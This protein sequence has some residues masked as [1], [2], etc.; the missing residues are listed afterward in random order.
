MLFTQKYA[1]RKLEEIFGNDEA[2]ER[3]KQWILNW[4]RGKR[5]KPIL[6]HGPPGTGKSALAAALRE[7]FDLEL[8]EMSASDLRNRQ[9]VERVMTN[10]L[11]GSS[12]FGR[13]KLIFIDDVDALQKSDSGGSTAISRLLG[14]AAAP[15]MLTA[16]NIWE[17]KLAGIRTSCELLAFKK[18]SKPSIAKILKKITEKEKLEISEDLMLRILEG[19]S[20]DVRSA[21]N[22]LQAHNPGT[23]EREKDIFERV[24][25]VFKSTT[26]Q[27]AKK[28]VEG[29]ADYEILKLWIDEN[30]PYEYETAEDVA[31]AYNS[32][33]R[34]DVFEG[35]IRKSHW[36]Y[37]RYVLDLMTAGV[38][39]SKKTR[40][41][42]FTKYQF[43]KYLRAMAG[44]VE[45]RAMNKLVGRKI[46]ARTHDSWKFS[47]SYLPIL[48]ALAKE[49]K[50]ALMDFYGLDDDEVAFVMNTDS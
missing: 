29:D 42:K 27:D 4:M 1:P 20:G 6:V 45:K 24:L 3:I 30:I 19:A 31:A 2:R 50:T 41:Q 47:L 10:A 14:E 18:I 35:R 13:T 40:Y 28:A 39:L 16:T 8:I 38:A 33:S 43:P 9:H 36:T 17:K 25:K 15:I 5:Q 32:L 22:D 34:A 49:R 21:I 44:T 48:K 7:E 12:L 26:Y 37:L 46:G 23:R 11:L